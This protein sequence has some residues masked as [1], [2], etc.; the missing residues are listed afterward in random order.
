MKQIESIVSV[1][2]RAKRLPRK[3]DLFGLSGCRPPSFVEE[4][5][6]SFA[7]PNKLVI[8]ETITGAQ[9]RV[10]D[11]L[12]F[13]GWRAR[14]DVDKRYIFDEPVSYIVGCMCPKFLEP[15]KIRPYERISFILYGQEAI[16]VPVRI[17]LDLVGYD[18]HVC[19]DPH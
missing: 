14:F 8:N 10:S 9:L 11:D 4:L 2:L 3:V 16:D 1:R 19:L 17:E 15:I 6:T 13:I 12:K 7:Q 5:E 18:G